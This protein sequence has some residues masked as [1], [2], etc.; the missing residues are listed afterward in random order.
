MDKG[1]VEIAARVALDVDPLDVRLER[2]ALRDV[3]RVL[4]VDHAARPVD[5]LRTTPGVSKSQQ[6]LSRRRGREVRLVA[7]A[8]VRKAGK[9]SPPEVNSRSLPAKP[10]TGPSTASAGTSDR[11]AWPS[12]S[13]GPSCRRGPTTTRT[14]SSRSC[15]RGSARP[16]WRRGGSRRGHSCRRR[17]PRT[18]SSPTTRCCSWSTR[19]RSRP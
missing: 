3:G 14:G 4:P 1:Q 6:L 19:C 8:D 12:V 9:N 11:S 7:A 15:R 13:S 18:S 2:V 5:R 17:L 16:C 10:R